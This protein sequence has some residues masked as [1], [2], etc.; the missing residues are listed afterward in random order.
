MRS[1]GSKV[2]SLTAAGLLLVAGL[3]TAVAE[4]KPLDVS[5]SAR[6]VS[7]RNP[8]PGSPTSNSEYGGLAM[9]L[10]AIGPETT[11]VPC[12][13]CVTGAGGNNI[14][15]PWPVFTVQQGE[16]L[17]ISTWFQSSTYTG[18]CTVGLILKNA[19]TIVT[20]ASYPWPGGCEAGY[21]YGVIFTVPVPTETGPTTVIGQ[22]AGGGTNKSGTVSFMN[23]Q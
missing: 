6:G 22:I 14:G 12:A 20:T 8:N 7:M 10:V 5:A 4:D 15:L 18:A 16:T 17:T 21:L 1:Y 3:S 11:G 2:F 19:G 9:T 13:Q 23:V